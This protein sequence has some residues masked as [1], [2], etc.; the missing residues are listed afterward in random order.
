MHQQTTQTTT[1]L[2]RIP[3]NRSVLYAPLSNNVGLPITPHT[4]SLSDWTSFKTPCATFHLL[5]CIAKTHSANSMSL[6]AATLS[7]DPF[8]SVKSR[9]WVATRRLQPK[10][11]E[12][13]VLGS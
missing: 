2:V 8:S 10:K 4:A 11:G 6:V 12:W 13:G 5:A 1:I 7:H 3:S 9:P